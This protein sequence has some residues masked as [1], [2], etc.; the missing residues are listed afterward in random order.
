MVD[1]IAHA[2]STA[3]KRMQTAP[4][5]NSLVDLSPNEWKLDS[6]CCFECFQLKLADY[7]C[8]WKPRVHSNPQPTN[9]SLLIPPSLHEMELL[10]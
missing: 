2:L 7:L 8:Q 1:R 4:H 10:G 3:R 5:K 6:L 9:H